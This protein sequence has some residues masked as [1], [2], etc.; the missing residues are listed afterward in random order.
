MIQG[1]FR[2]DG[3]GFKAVFQPRPPLH[4]QYLRAYVTLSEAKGLPRWSLVDFI[5]LGPGP[6]S[7]LLKFHVGNNGI[8]TGDWGVAE[9]LPPDLNGEEVW[10]SL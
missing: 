10:A 9:F 4:S 7:G 5:R 2:D 1:Y 6:G 3:E 8:Y